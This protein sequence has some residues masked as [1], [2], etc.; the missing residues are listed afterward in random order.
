MSEQMYFVSRED[1]YLYG[2]EDK[3]CASANWVGDKGNLIRM[4]M[5]VAEKLFGDRLAMLTLV[6]VYKSDKLGY[7]TI[8][9]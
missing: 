6:P 4:T 8:P 9:E 2:Y 7:V 1:G 3:S 5:P